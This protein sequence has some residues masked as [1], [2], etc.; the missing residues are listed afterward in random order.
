[1]TSFVYF[2]QP[3]GGGPIRIGFSSRPG[4]R[5]SHLTSFSPVKLEIITKFPADQYVEAWLHDHFRDDRLHGEWFKPSFQLFEIIE[6]VKRTGWHPILPTDKWPRYATKSRQMSGRKFR[7]IRVR[8]LGVSAHD[9]AKEYEVSIGTVRCWE[10]TGP[11]AAA[12][13]KT[14]RF[15]K[16][17]GKQVV[18]DDIFTPEDEIAA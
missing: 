1:M 3:I 4:V 15:A 6:G 12:V 18:F 8:V 7:R 14:F 11:S 5:L 16:S 9:L 2:M 13:L 17:L 10:S